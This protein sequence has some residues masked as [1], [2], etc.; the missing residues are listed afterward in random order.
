MFKSWDPSLLSGRWRWLMTRLVE[1]SFISPRFG[2]A[3]G[4]KHLSQPV[5]CILV[6]PSLLGGR[7]YHS[8]PISVLESIPWLWRGPPRRRGIRKGYPL[9]TGTCVFALSHA[10]VDLPK[11]AGSLSSTTAGAGGFLIACLP[12]L[13]GVVH[14]SALP[15]MTEAT[16]DL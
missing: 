2:H 12:L 14:Q 11:D 8:L 16:G 6:V 10:V 15:M 4:L 1:M 5:S 13:L 7:H 3:L 9:G